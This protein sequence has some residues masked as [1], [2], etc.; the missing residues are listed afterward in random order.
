MRQLLILLIFPLS[1]FTQTGIEQIRND[2][3]VVNFI[4]AVG[5][6]YFPYTKG[7]RL[8]DVSFNLYDRFFI[9]RE[10]LSEADGEFTDS[11]TAKRWIVEDFNNDKLRDLVYYGR[12]CLTILALHI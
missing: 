10:K 2:S 4:R 3:D 7:E 12:I 9:Y 11:I 6:E 8:R 1:V 5:H